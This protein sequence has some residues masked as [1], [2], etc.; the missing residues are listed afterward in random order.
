MYSNI[1]VPLALDE[2][3]N[4]DAALNVAR[5]LA[6]PGARI[7]IMHVKDEVPGFAISYMPEGYGAELKRAI[8]A[9]LEKLAAEFENGVAVVREG[10]PYHEIVDYAREAGTDCIV[11]ASHRPGLGDY[12][13]G[14]TAARVVR[15]APCAVMV[16]R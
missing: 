10:Q 7:T 11:I 9:T 14:S 5:A 3:H 8:Q 1:L 4:P 6:A 15:H 16:M 13:I 2:D 12:L